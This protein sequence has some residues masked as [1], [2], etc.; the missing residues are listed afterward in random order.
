[1]AYWHTVWWH[2]VSMGSS[3]SVP[4]CPKGYDAKDFSA[5]LRLYDELDS[6]GD[7][8]LTSKEVTHI[9]EVHVRNKILL[10]DT[11]VQSQLCKKA[12]CEED[13]QR[14]LNNEISAIKSACA[15]RINGVTAQRTAEL[16]QRLGV[17]DNR[18]STLRAE[19]RQWEVA[20][21]PEKQEMFMGAVG[22]GFSEFFKYMR[23]R[24]QNL[25]EIYPEHYT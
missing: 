9:A 24:T 2:V 17:I 5:I 6:D 15:L 21:V 3:V 4:K 11:E 12:L 23:S 22:R 7:F 20:T 14:Q 8:L 19:I 1:M 25:R 10:Q 18:V 16:K 13:G